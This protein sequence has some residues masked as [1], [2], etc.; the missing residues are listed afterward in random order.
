MPLE[1]RILRAKPPRRDCFTILRLHRSTSLWYFSCTLPPRTQ[2]APKQRRLFAFLAGEYE[3]EGEEEEKEVG[4]RKYGLRNLGSF[5][6]TV[7]E[8]VKKQNAFIVVIV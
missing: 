4:G 8:F 5:R 7:L 3:E 6:R 1:W 2:K